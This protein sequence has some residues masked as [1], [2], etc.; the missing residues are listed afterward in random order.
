M[1][2][3]SSCQIESE[4]NRVKKFHCRDCLKDILKYLQDDDYVDVMGISGLRRTGKTTLMYQAMNELSEEERKKALNIFVYNNDMTQDIVDTIEKMSR[5]G[6]KYVFI[7]EVTRAEDFIYNASMYADVNARLDRV[8]IVLTGTDSL[9]L[10]RSSQNELFDRIRSVRTTHMP[11][12]E[13]V[14]VSNKNKIDDYLRFSGIFDKTWMPEIEGKNEGFANADAAGR[15]VAT[16]IGMNIQNTLRHEGY[17]DSFGGLRNLLRTGE[18]ISAIQRVVQD[19]NHD[20]G[21]DVLASVFRSRDFSIA[22]DSLARSRDPERRSKLLKQLNIGPI[23]EKLRRDL[24]IINPEESIVKLEDRHVKEIEEY[25]KN[26]EVI[27]EAPRK[28]LIDLPNL[29]VKRLSSQPGLRYAQAHALLQAVV[30]NP[31][32]Q[33]AAQRDKVLSTDRIMSAAIG[34]MLEDAVMLDTLYAS[35]NLQVFKYRVDSS[36]V[37]GVEYDMVLRDPSTNNCTVIEIKHT[38]TKDDSQLKAFR[39]KLFNEKFESEV[40]KICNKIVLYGGEY[41]KTYDYIYYENFEKWLKYLD[42]G[43]E[44]AID[45]ILSSKNISIDI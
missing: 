6:Y 30:E 17:E 29:P 40:G 35:D 2:L 24:N 4:L 38:H 32:F 23:I 18:L 42:N 19:N 10:N 12:R 8:K 44:Y 41:D 20:F 43:T 21:L 15:Y 9:K 27:V 36:D 37:P 31:Q 25:L 1:L 22:R 3:R 14:R 26:L 5:Q 13:W 45:K 33:K 28:S 39:N 11:Y 34:A 16:A 7:D